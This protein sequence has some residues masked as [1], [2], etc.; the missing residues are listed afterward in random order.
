MVPKGAPHVGGSQAMT[1]CTRW[2]ICGPA[3]QIESFFETFFGLAQ[4]S[5]VSPKA[6][7]PDL[8]QMALVM[9]TLSQRTIWRAAAYRAN[10]AV[11]RTS[12]DRAT[13]PGT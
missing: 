6:G 1:N 11:W 5:K 7:L 3:L 13:A 2:W 4:D 12:A 8:F 10:A 9:R